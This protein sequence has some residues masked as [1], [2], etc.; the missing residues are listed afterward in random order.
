MTR[1]IWLSLAATAAALGLSFYIY[2]YRFEMLPEMVPTH[3]NIYGQP[4]AFVPRDNILVNFLL[5]PG[6]MLLLIGLTFLLPWLSPQAFKVD[7][8]HGTF[9]YL[10]FLVVM[11]FGYIH[12]A[13][14]YGS[15]KDVNLDIGKVLVAGMFLFF[16]LIGNVLGKVRRNFWMGVR[17]PW[18]L[19]S[20]TVWNRTHRVAAWLWTFAGLLGFVGVLAGVPLWIA[21]VFFLVMALAPVLHSLVL[22]KSLERQGKLEPVGS[23]NVTEGA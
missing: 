7:R 6:V 22:Y 19:A 15:L 9:E 5:V 14:L 1:W 3:W 10:M 23:E 16:A 13:I 4:D 21:F 8:F 11:L 20:E 2:T 18:T 17:T 12:G